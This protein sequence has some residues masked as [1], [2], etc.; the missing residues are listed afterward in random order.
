MTGTPKTKPPKNDEEWAR[1]VE[2]RLNQAEHPVSTR[3]G[4][5]VLSTDPNTD[6]L[7]ASYV[8]GGSVILSAPPE[9]GLD[10]PDA[11]APAGFPHIKVTRALTQSITSGGGVYI[12]WDAVAR[13]TGGFGFTAPGRSVTVTQAGIYLITLNVYGTNTASAAINLAAAIIVNDQEAF[14]LIENFYTDAGSVAMST[15]VTDTIQL[16]AG[17]AVSG[18]LIVSS[19]MS[20]GTSARSGNCVTS[21]SITRL[22]IDI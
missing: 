7:I 18:Q 21:L 14:A 6:N 3:A 20:I 1:N 17:D 4:N 2:T 12:D 10:D 8:N 16:A 19:T 13:T 22:P 11:V 5:W 9:G 15:G